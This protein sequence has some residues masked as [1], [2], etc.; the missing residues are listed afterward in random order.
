MSIAGIPANLLLPNPQ[1]TLLNTEQYFRIGSQ[2][3]PIAAQL[4]ANAN[5][6]ALGLPNGGLPVLAQPQLVPTSLTNG[7][8]IPVSASIPVTPTPLIANQPAIFPPPGAQQGVIQPNGVGPAPFEGQAPAN[9]VQ[10]KVAKAQ[11]KIQAAR[12]IQNR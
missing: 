5:R 2:L 9:N 1:Q 10:R 12:A 4:Q 3:S 6:A 11:S 8:L 7:V